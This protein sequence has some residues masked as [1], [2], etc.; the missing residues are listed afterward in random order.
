MSNYILCK[1]LKL[2]ADCKS[3]RNGMYGKKN[4]HCLKTVGLFSEFL[5][6][7][8]KSNQISYKQANITNN[9]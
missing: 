4:G 8:R 3:K 6:I 1:C 7:F 2:N 5:R 9:F